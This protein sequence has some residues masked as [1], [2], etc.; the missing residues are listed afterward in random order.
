VDFEGFFNGLDESIDRATICFSEGIYSHKA[1]I[2]YFDPQ[3]AQK[4]CH[5]ILQMTRKGSTS[6]AMVSSIPKFWANLEALVQS[7]SLNLIESTITRVFCMQGVLKFHYWL[8]DIIP[9]AIR[10]ISKPNH[11][12]KTWID[13]LVTDVRSSLG[14][15]A[16]FHSSEYL[17]LG[18][19]Y[20]YTTMPKSFK[21]DDTEQLTSVV[22]SILKKWLCFPADD[23]YLAKLT[24]LDIVVTKFPP[25]ILFLDKIWEMYD[26][27]FSTLFN[28][29]W[30]MRRSKAKLVEA[31]ENFKDKISSHSFTIA[32]SSSRRKLD[33]LSELIN[34]WMRS[35]GVDS[36]TTEIVSQIQNDLFVFS[37][38]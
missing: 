24:L 25:S 32:D 12:S 37:L 3:R 26:T 9:A 17:E 30:G 38:K 4:T 10:R 22:S 16:T 36:N 13:R 20:P 34:Q 7:S 35:T 6:T 31:L 19:S 18:F 1:L 33:S 5:S 23:D 28:N 21:Y 27:P 8:L 11:E 2:S 15:G 29:N 14:T